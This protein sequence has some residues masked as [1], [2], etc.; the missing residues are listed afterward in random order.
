L[1]KSKSKVNCD[2]LKFFDKDLLSEV[3]YYMAIARRWGYPKTLPTPSQIVP[4][5]GNVNMMDI[6]TGPIVVLCNGGSGYLR[7]VKQ[8]YGFN[9]LANL[10]LLSGHYVVL[11][12]NGGELDNVA[13]SCSFTEKLSFVHS[14][15]VLSQA[16]FIVTTDTAMMHAADA[17][18]IRGV[19]L[20]GPT[21]L[22][23]NGPVN[24]TLKVMISNVE[25]RPCQH[26]GSGFNNCK[27][28][29]C[30][31]TIKP[32]DVYRKVLSLI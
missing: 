17:L 2:D 4:H 21:S 32:Q 14:C 12:G 6:A 9:E 28:I 16:N 1:F 3:Q 5:D 18:K 27:P 31:N 24:D 15:H 22:V 30:M 19:A 29:Y 13:C 11:L 25:C 26:K 23:K 7:R 20:F 8:W 10:L